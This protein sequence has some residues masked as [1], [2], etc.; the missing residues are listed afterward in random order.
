MADVDTENA[1]VVIVG[2]GPVG[3]TLANLLGVY[4]I[5]TT[6]LER[7]AAI[8]DT[9]RAVAIDD[10]ALRAWQAAG[11]ADDIV[12]DLSIPPEQTPWMRYRDAR[13]KVFMRLTRFPE[14][15]GYPAVAGFIQPTT[16]RVLMRGLSRF[17]HVSLRFGHEV[18][19]VIPQTGGVIVSGARTDGTRFHIRADYAIA[20]DGGQSGIRKSLGIAMTGSTYRERWLVLDTLERGPHRDHRDF[21]VDVWCDPARPT[22]TVPRRY[23]HRRWE[24]MLH[25]NEGEQSMLTGATIRELL[26]NRGVPATAEVI[27]RL[28]YVF[29]ARIAERYREGRIL[30]AGDAAHVTPP[31]AGQ[32]LST[33]IRDAFNLAWKLAAVTAGTASPALLD[34]Y[35]RERRGHQKR[36]IRLAEW[37][38]FAMMPHNRVHAA[39]MM[40]VVRSSAAIPPVRR[41]LE[42]GGPRAVP[43]YRARSGQVVVQGYGGSKI[44]GRYCIQPH[45]DFVRPGTGAAGAGAAGADAAG[46]AANNARLDDALGTGFAVVGFRTDPRPILSTENL[47]FWKGMGARFVRIERR[48]FDARAASMT[49]VTDRERA[50]EEWLGSKPRSSVIRPDRFVAADTP[51]SR[52]DGATAALR[53][54]LLR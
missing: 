54:I 31:F 23:G 36:M 49:T 40:A 45:V 4:G 44:T 15:H 35:E 21:E 7:N 42:Q 46:V 22:V 27:R 47:S 2:A 50:I 5:R 24:F 6:I 52:A 43:H 29:N 19:K 38:G 12:D 11:L 51:S 1:Q 10:E 20:C 37:L 18:R 48:G 39:M 17:A 9:P 33:G 28:V 26:A 32:G 14:R 30:L 16:E 41:F 53:A 8:Y 3:T 13:G 25:A 34:S